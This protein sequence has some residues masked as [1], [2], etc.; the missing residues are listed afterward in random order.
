[1]DLS[2]VKKGD[3][4]SVFYKG[5][6]VCGV[7]V[8]S[9]TEEFIVVEDVVGYYGLESWRTDGNHRMWPAFGDWTIGR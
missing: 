5:R 7:T 6:R 4:L 8:V 2:D 9:V 1:M 3:A